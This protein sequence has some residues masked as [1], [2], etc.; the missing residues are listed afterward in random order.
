MSE[1]TFEPVPEKHHFVSMFSAYLAL[2]V[3]LAF[4]VVAVAFTVDVAVDAYVT[5]TGKA[6][7]ATI[8]SESAGASKWSHL[9][10]RFR[11]PNVNQPDP[12]RLVTRFFREPSANPNEASIHALTRSRKFATDAA[13]APTVTIRYLPDSPGVYVVDEDFDRQLFKPAVMLASYLMTFIFGTVFARQW[14]TYRAGR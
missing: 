7:T 2:F 6:V 13:S 1:N 11:Y 4:F 10:V 8:T 12:Y 3:A 9:V 5:A 14:L